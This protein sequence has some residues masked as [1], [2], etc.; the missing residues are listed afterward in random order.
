MANINTNAPVAQF[1]VGVGATRFYF[2][3]GD[4][5]A[6]CIETELSAVELA[7]A[8]AA[9]DVFRERLTVQASKRRAEAYPS[10]NSPFGPMP[11]HQHPAF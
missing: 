5:D 9:L 4:T 3:S 1:E 11:Y 8:L 7:M 2:H 6:E 10:P